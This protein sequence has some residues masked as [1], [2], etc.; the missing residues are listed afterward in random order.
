V[1]AALLP[2]ARFSDGFLRGP[3]GAAYMAGA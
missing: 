1:L 3:C 2:A